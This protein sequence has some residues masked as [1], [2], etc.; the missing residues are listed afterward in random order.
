[1]TNVNIKHTVAIA[2]LSPV[3]LPPPS[4]TVNSR[5][6]SPQSLRSNTPTEETTSEPVVQ[7]F[8]FLIRDSTLNPSATRD[9]PGE[10]IALV[11]KIKGT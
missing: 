6:P 9:G 5:L 2:S 7:D 10:V 4:T 3:K 8:E 1:M 11:Q